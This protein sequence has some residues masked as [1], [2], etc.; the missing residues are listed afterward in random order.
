MA[1]GIHISHIKEKKEEKDIQ[2]Q[3]KKKKLCI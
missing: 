1:Y 2:C 3:E